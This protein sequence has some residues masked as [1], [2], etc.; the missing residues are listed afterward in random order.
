MIINDLKTVYHL[1]TS[2]VQGD[3]H[4]E[5]MGSFYRHQAA[6]YDGFRERLLRGRRELYRNIPV[7]RG[8]VLVDM[9][10]GTGANLECLGA[11]IDDFDK[12]FIVDVSE[13]LL[14]VARER[15]Q[16][17]KWRN[18]EAVACDAAGFSPGCP[19]DTVM[20]SY[21]LSMM[22]NWFAAVDR[23]SSLLQTGGTL[24]AVDFYVSPKFA[25]SG[26]RQHGWWTRTFW[27]TWFAR[28][29][30]H[31]KSDP[32]DYLHYKFAVRSLTENATSLPFV[33]PVLGQVPYYTFI[34]TKT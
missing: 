12:V 27:P 22:P 14:A 32:L 31:L 23:A 9:G 19:V 16:E 25:G 7:R 33:P 11:R 18:V 8:D 3:S 28:D 15:I 5:R 6:H 10:G 1:V 2:P 29:N 21:S 17:N 30:V 13:P 20:F 4:E 34:G 24:G 26:R